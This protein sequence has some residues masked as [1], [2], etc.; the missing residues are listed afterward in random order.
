MNQLSKDQIKDRLLKRAAKQWGYSD[1]ELENGFD[2]IVNLLFDVCAKELEK[3]SGEIYS[4]RRRMT[5]RLIDI[6]TPTAA[7]K[8]TPASAILKAYPVENEV[9]LHD[10]HQFYYQRKETN[11]YNPIET[12]LKSYFFG[13]TA[14]VKLTRNKLRYVV[15]PNGV[16][17]ISKDQFRES[18]GS[19]EFLKPSPYGKA[20]IGIKHEGNGIVKDLMFYFYQKNIDFRTTFY[21]FLPKA[22]WFLNDYELH[23]TQGYNNDASD[24]FASESLSSESFYHIEKTQEHVNEFYSKQFITVKDILTIFESDTSVPKEFSQFLP[25]ENLKELEAEKLLWLRVEFPNVINNDM[26]AEM[27]CA[28]NCFPAINK[29]LNEMQGNIK[30]LLNIYPL[31]LGQEF[32]LELLSVTDDKNEEFDIVTSTEERNEDKDFTYLRFGGIARFDERNATEEINYLIDLVRDE[33]AA[34]S[35][36]GHDFTDNNLKE[37]NQIISRFRNKMVQLDMQN[38]NSP[39]LVLNTKDK[40]RKGSLFVKYWTTNGESANKINAFSRLTVYKGSEFEKDGIAFLSST[41]GGKD[42]LTNSQKIYAYRENLISNQR[43]VTRQDL[44]ILSKNHY[45]DAISGVEVKNGIQTSLDEN[46]GYTPTID[47]YIHRKNPE[48]YTDEEWHFLSENLK[49]TIEKRAVN[50]IP[51]RVIYSA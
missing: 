10:H 49:L 25:T 46:V 41:R 13:P 33:A 9:I 45:G 22:K 35:R 42:E 19:S 15:L 12:N 23:T 18:V 11:P 24:D 38:A 31:S 28:T 7:T 51:F 39:Y 21:H 34:F 17:E 30:N 36:L 43:V 6:L 50:I 27:F 8:A 48:I 44:I 40:N 3:I 26:L 37:I 29:K 1:I 4:S 16:Q 47:L 32:F 2:P 20:W 5:E 14:P